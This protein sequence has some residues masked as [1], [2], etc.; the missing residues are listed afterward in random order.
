M[1]K[2]ATDKTEHYDSVYW[3]KNPGTTHH[4]VCTR[5]LNADVGE[6][7]M[8]KIALRV[9]CNNSEASTLCCMIRAREHWRVL[10]DLIRQGAVRSVYVVRILYSVVDSNRYSISACP[11]RVQQE[12]FI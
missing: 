4:G 11:T 12:D 8:N 1:F 10:V 7:S 3:Y 9:E 2:R 6:G 5:Q